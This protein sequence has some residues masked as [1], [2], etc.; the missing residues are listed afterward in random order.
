VQPPGSKLSIAAFPKKILLRFPGWEERSTTIPGGPLWLLK[1]R[2]K[3]HP[4]EL[5]HFRFALPHYLLK[6][7]GADFTRICATELHPSKSV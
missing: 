3:R 2:V 6:F 1:V 5:R 4:R 7:P